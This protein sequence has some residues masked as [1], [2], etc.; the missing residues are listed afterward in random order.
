MTDTLQSLRDR[1]L[2]LESLH[3][4]GDLGAEAYA[5]RRA[6]LERSLADL[7]MA[8]GPAASTPPAAPAPAPRAPRQRP[9][10]RLLSLVAAGVVAIAIGGYS[11]TGSPGFLFDGARAPRAEGEKAPHAF[12]KAQVAA[13]IDKLEARLKERPDDFEGWSMLG[14]TQMAL[15]EP[16]KAVAAY[17]RALELR[18]DDANLLADMADALAVQNG[19]SLAGEPA[20][21]VEKALKADPSNLKALMLAGTIAFDASDFAKAAQLWDRAA[22]VGPADHPL[23]RAAG[24]AAAEARQRGNLPPATAATPASPSPAA[25]TGATLSGS[26]TLAAALRAKAAPD[27][28]V[29]VFARAAEGS[30]M[31]V[32]LLRKQVRDLPLQFTLDDSMAMS[33]A[34]KLSTSGRVVVGA[35]ISKSGQAMPQAGDLEGF[36]APVEA[37]AKGIQIEIATERR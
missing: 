24:E 20:K 29:F 6:E 14:R 18:P 1:L 28:T 25:A 10:A 32:A 23:A 11:A 19:R 33:P 16:A 21:L 13:M 34:A 27:D 9:P 2:Q 37:G 35:R 3:A 12:D 26:V 7:V 4:A 22:Q 15:Q 8:A 5:R 36:S 17:R 30:R 31:P